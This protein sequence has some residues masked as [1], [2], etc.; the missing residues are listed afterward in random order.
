MSETRKLFKD[1]PEWSDVTP[2]EQDD[3]PHPVAPI[4]Y[5]TECFLFRHF[6][7]KFSKLF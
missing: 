7:L 4:D 2:V 3:G 6:T 1:R 5:S